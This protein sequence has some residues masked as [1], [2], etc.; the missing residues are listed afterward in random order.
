[1]F[2]ICIYESCRLT[3]L[4]NNIKFWNVGISSYASLLEGFGQVLVLWPSQLTHV[5]LNTQKRAYLVGIDFRP[6]DGLSAVRIP[7]R[8]RDVQISSR[9]HL[10]S[11]SMGT[12]LKQPGRDGHSPS[13]NAWVKNKWNYTTFIYMSSCRVQGYFTLLS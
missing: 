9:I 4:K 7:R 1:M 13:F 5:I 10:S 8:P 6:R 3:S 11:Y 12:G 2:A